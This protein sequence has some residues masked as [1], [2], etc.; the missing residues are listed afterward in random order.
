MQRRWERL[1]LI[2]D[3]RD[4]Q[5]QVGRPKGSSGRVADIAPNICS[6][7]KVQSSVLGGHYLN[8]T[9]LPSLLCIQVGPRDYEWPMGRK[10]EEPMGCEQLTARQLRNGYAF[11]TIPFPSASQRQRLGSSQERQSHR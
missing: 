7:I 3:I 1:H 8:M 4:H 5:G 10:M 2:G 6:P 9:T 11:F